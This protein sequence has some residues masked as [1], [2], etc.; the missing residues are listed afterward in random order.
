MYLFIG[1]MRV[2]INSIEMTV[3]L[4][5]F[6]HSVT[7]CV[8]FV[9]PNFKAKASAPGTP[10]VSNVGPHSA[11]VSWTKPRSDGG[12]PIKGYFIA[13][14][15]FIVLYLELYCTSLICVWIHFFCICQIICNF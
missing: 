11:D 9:V 14:L 8:V 7:S 15:Q 5:I 6:S 3:S 4:Y 1:N 2:C 10:V 12:S 13:C